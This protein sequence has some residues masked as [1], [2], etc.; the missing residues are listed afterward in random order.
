MS[1][2]KLQIALEFMILFSFVLIVFIFLFAL[3]ASQ[4]AQ[5]QNNQVFS[6]L[7]L[8]A[9]GVASQLDRAMQA[10]SGYSAQFPITS[11]GTLTYQLYIAKN[12]A[13][14]VNATVGSQSMQAIAYSSVKQVSSNP[15]FL[16]P[17]TFYYSLPI[18]NGTLNIQNY[19]GS[20]CVD[21]T[22]I[23][24]TGSASNVSLTS[25]VVHAANFNGQSSYINIGSV[26]NFGATDS[27]TVTAWMYLT[28]KTGYNRYYGIAKGYSDSG[29]G[30]PAWDVGFYGD[31]AMFSIADA[32]TEYRVGQ[33]GPT[34][35]Y[36]KWYFV[37]FKVDRASRLATAYL[38]NI[39]IGTSVDISS[40]GSLS[41]AALFTIG[42]GSYQN[43]YGAF[44]GSISNIQIYNAAL[45]AQQTQQLYQGG[46]S[47]LPFSGN[48]M[49][50]WPLNGNA[51]DYTGNGN[52]GANYGTLLFTTAAQLSAKVTDQAGNPV[53]NNLVGFT[54]TSGNFTATSSFANYTNANGIAT[55]FLNQRNN[56]GP[57]LVKAMAFNSNTAL[58]AN[59]VGWWPLNNGQGNV[60]SDISGNRNNGAMKNL[61]YWSMPNYVASLDG[62]SGYIDAGSGNSLAITGALTVS[63]WIK[64]SV[65]Q[66]YEGAITKG[67]VSGD[68]DY[69]LYLTGSGTGAAFYIKNAAG[70][71][72]TVGSTTLNWADGNWHEYT[73]VFS[74][75][76]LY[77][78]FDGQ[79][80]GS[81]TTALTEVRP[82][83]N[84]L[85]FGRGWVASPFFN[86]SFTNVQVYNAALSASQVQQSYQQGIAALPFT[87]NLMGWW[88]L[89]G[90]AADFS[91]NGNNATLYG[92]VNFASTSSIPSTNTN[93]TSM[94]TGNFNG[95]SSYISIANANSLDVSSQFTV[96]SWIKTTSSV[97]VIYSS[98]SGSGGWQ[99][100]VNG[101]AAGI[102][103]A[104][105][106][107]IF[108]Q[109]QVNDGRW[110]QVVGIVQ[111]NYRA[112]YVDGVL[113]AYSAALNNLANNGNNDIGAQCAGS[114][115]L[116]FLG[117]IANVQVYNT[118]LTSAQILKLYQQGVSGVPS[119]S[120]IVGWWPL[121]GNSK[122]YSSNNKNGTASNVIYVQQ[123]TVPPYLLSSLG[124][125]GVNFN[126]Q[127]SYLTI[128]SNTLFFSDALSASFWFK[129]SDW[130]SRAVAGTFNSNNWMFYRNSFWSKEQLG[131]LT[132]YN[133]IGGGQATLLPT[134]TGFQLNTWYHVVASRS[135]SGSS[136]TAKVYVNGVLQTTSTV[137]DFLSWY[138]D[139][140]QPL[141][142]G[143]G[144]A[145]YALNG[146]VSNFQLYNIALTAQQV[147][148]I[149][150]S[151]APPAASALIP[152]SWIP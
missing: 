94:L 22:C 25:Q 125:S 82:S 107:T 21:Y 145:G 111:N 65:K 149:Y 20:I 42:Q 6:Q 137:N 12:G 103:T 127:S 95:V 17:N 58:T 23:P 69:M 24:T 38:N 15:S 101:G 1:Q 80:V 130:D 116:P 120:G 78:Y 99:L 50:W 92:N 86:G 104:L 89:W 108:S 19:R 133:K 102:W 144:G 40:I 109:G 140:L 63:T 96:T 100:Y 83:S 85:K 62:K 2:K 141:S 53:A 147:Q 7:Q 31:K 126:G 39:Q 3:I 123:R 46:I 61:A 26:M 45:T 146:S 122:D 36:N 59:L 72:D 132:Y 113:S 35:S 27:F 117:Q 152:L 88:P 60:V 5:V 84:S 115:S 14:I 28:T 57:A 135:F 33:D 98:W 124:G 34:V 129:I 150:Q 37:V 97:G 79:L 10:G 41:N 8:I 90:D 139:T 81:K 119:S 49:G 93:A 75:S 142:I 11:V 151:Q 64:T 87:S 54:T 105:G 148:Q 76:S 118:T 29:L 52:N 55:A 43:G 51:N 128:P 91:G 44:S 77:M 138:Q 32:S 47:G 13:V 70:T 9:Q 121:N 56:N 114:C 136:A 106:G 143:K 16:Q 73:G 134:F 112:I 18:G 131:F 68:Y 48:L 67:P 110:H 4:R 66:S 74:G 30:N 71:G